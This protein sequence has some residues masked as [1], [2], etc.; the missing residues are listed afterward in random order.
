MVSAPTIDPRCGGPTCHVVVGSGQRS[1]HRRCSCNTRRF[2]AP[3]AAL[4]LRL[5]GSGEAQQTRADAQEC[6]FR[7]GLAMDIFLCLD[8]SLCGHGVCYI[9]CM[10]EHAR[11]RQL[12]SWTAR[13]CLITLVT[14]P[15][16]SSLSSLRLQCGHASYISPA[17]STS[18]A[19][20]VAQYTY[21]STLATINK[22]QVCLRIPRKLP[23]SAA[24]STISRG[25][26][27]P[28][29]CLTE[30]PMDHPVFLPLSNNSDMNVG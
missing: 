4:A 24:G 27:W 2:Q 11:T 12:W 21:V 22:F 20:Q 6:N 29:S 25:L 8:S 13:T 17:S 30:P 15:P 5:V 16:P 3:F 14:F 7:F 18:K 1:Q 9:I 10:K 19:F 26:P 23:P 28:D